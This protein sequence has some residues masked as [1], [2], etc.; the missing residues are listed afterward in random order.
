M[1]KS[2]NKRQKVKPSDNDLEL[3]ERDER[4]AEDNTKK[5]PGYTDSD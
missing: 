2:Q 3:Q 4:K 5:N 1:K